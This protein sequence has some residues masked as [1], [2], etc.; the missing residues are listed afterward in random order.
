MNK[1]FAKQIGKNMEVYVDGMLT[2]SK[3][4]ADHIA[5]LSQIFDQLE[6]YQMKL[7][8]TECVLAYKKAGSLCTL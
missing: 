4:V 6:K 5:N 3:K 1:V 7:N 8:P 2:K